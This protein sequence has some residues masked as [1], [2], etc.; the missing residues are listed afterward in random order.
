MKTE[1]DM[2]EIGS[3]M[4]AVRLHS[5]GGPA[6]LILEEIET[7][8]VQDGEALVRV[9]AAAITRDEL[10]WSTDRLPAI[11]SYEMSGEVVAVAPGVETVGVGDA[12]FALTPF[13]RDGAAADYVAVPAAV[14]AG[15]PRSIDHVGAAALPLAALSAWQGLFDHGHLE[16]GQRVL[17]TGVSG[18]V[19]HLATQLA[20]ARG[21]HVI[22]STSASEEEARTWGVDQV[23]D[24]AG[25]EDLEPVD[26]VFDTAGGDLLR[27]SPTVVRDGGRIVSVAEDPPEVADGRSIE[28]VYFVVEPNRE[29]LQ[30]IA[31]LVDAGELR[32]A[33]D[34]VFP[35]ADARGAFERSEQRGKRG[36]VVLRVSD[37]GAQ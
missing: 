33:I 20:H 10:G 11:P 34:S 1:A 5:A 23:I 8:H 24:G 7:P 6:G 12:V 15:A 36:K 26:L 19:G 35:L 4:R 32:P 13:D 31:R 14:L 16:Q 28:T 18:G 17:V 37:G 27:R 2:T 29:Q 9:D 22:G 3:V 21:A 25:L 30:D